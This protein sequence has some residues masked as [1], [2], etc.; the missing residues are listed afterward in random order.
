[1]DQVVQLDCPWAPDAGA[2]TPAVFQQEAHPPKVVYLPSVAD[3]SNMPM[4]VLRFPQ[5]GI[6][7]SVKRGYHRTPGR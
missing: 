2:P 4:A 3:A 6:A 1:M 7:L 5:F